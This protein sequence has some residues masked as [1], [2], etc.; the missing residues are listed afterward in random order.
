MARRSAARPLHL[1]PKIVSTRT[2]QSRAP[3][4]VIW[5]HSLGVATCVDALSSTVPNVRFRPC[6]MPSCCNCQ[7]RSRLRSYS[8]PLPSLTTKE[9]ELDVV[10]AAVL[11][12][13][14]GGLARS[15]TVDEEVNYGGEVI[16][17]VLAIAWHVGNGRHHQYT[18]SAAYPQASLC[19]MSPRACRQSH[20]IRRGLCHCIT[21]SPKANAQHQHSQYLSG[22]PRDA[23]YH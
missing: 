6:R 14:R 11:H 9:D 2:A 19:L 18:L 1:S 5:S 12:V 16:N 8:R 7:R 10:A 4:I 22:R 3:L 13:G 17:A 15:V 23:A 20:Q 21:P